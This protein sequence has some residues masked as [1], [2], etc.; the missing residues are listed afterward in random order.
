MWL[1][2]DLSENLCDEE[3]NFFAGMKEQFKASC[4]KI[5]FKLIND[6]AIIYFK[7][8]KLHSLLKTVKMQ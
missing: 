6:E 4:V 8:Y 7:Y 5:F 3:R 1:K 2:V